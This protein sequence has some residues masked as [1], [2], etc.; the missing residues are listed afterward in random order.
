MIKELARALSL[1]QSTFLTHTQS[2]ALLLSLSFKR[3]GPRK[4]VETVKQLSGMVR[5]WRIFSKSQRL[6]DLSI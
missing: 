6:K 1:T 2:T 3:V 5:G 4:V